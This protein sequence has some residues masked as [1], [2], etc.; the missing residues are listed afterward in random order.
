MCVLAPNALIQY[1]VWLEGEGAGEQMTQAN[2]ILVTSVA[3]YKLRHRFND[4]IDV[5]KFTDSCQF[6]RWAR[7]V[8][9]GLSLFKVM[10]LS[11]SIQMAPLAQSSMSGS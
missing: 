4:S 6:H 2:D 3:Y 1:Q 10:Y 8:E 11:E 7:L 9:K 5:V